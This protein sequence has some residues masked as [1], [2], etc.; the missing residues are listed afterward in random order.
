MAVTILSFN[1]TTQFL[2][3]NILTPWYLTYLSNLVQN[4]HKVYCNLTELNVLHINSVIVDGKVKKSCDEGI[5]I[6]YFGVFIV[7]WS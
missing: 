3:R 4:I 6:Q 7:L 5:F 2:T 1:V